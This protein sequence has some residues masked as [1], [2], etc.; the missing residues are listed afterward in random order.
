MSL[1][2]GSLRL[3]ML[4][5]TL[6]D[7]KSNDVDEA[8]PVDSVWVGSGAGAGP[9]RLGGK[10][11]R[12]VASRL[13]LSW[14]APISTSMSAAEWIS[15]YIFLAAL[16]LPAKEIE[17]VATSSSLSIRSPSGASEPF[18]G[19]MSLIRVV[20]G[21]FVS[22]SALELANSARVSVRARFF[23]DGV[24]AVRFGIEALDA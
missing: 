1:V 11:G 16:V 20:R 23:L 8:T 3:L 18:S 21:V 14:M 2:T 10:R 19:N 5:S 13:C 22:S 17:E 15:T 7:W 12:Q 24:N 6:A 9:R 4:S